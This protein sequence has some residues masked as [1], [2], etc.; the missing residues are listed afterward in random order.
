MD[1]QNMSSIFDQLRAEH[2]ASPEGMPMEGMPADG[3]A[4]PQ[5]GIPTGENVPVEGVPQGTPEQALSADTAMQQNVP[6]NG[7]SAEMPD[8]NQILGTAN[9][10]IQ[11]QQ[12]QIAQLQQQAQ[13]AGQ[14]VQQQSQ[15]AQTAIEQ[16]MLQPPVIDFAQFQY[17]DDEQKSAMFQQYSNDM[18]AYMRSQMEREYAPMMQN[19]KQME[20]NQANEA[21]RS[22]LSQ[23]P[24]FGDNSALIDNIIAK[25]PELAS[26]QNPEL[27][28]QI[29]YLMAEGLGKMN[30]PAPSAP[31]TDDIL[32]MAME[33]PDVLKAI[34]EREAQ[35]IAQ[36]NQ[37]LPQFAATS[38]MSSAPAN[39]PQRPSTM[40]EA[41][42]NIEKNGLKGA[43]AGY[44]AH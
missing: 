4:I 3:T 34:K 16:A 14:A 7:V 41:W 42:G 21:A 1:E 40:E 33:N 25:T 32:K 28:Y 26:I 22:K 8:L 13:Q 38:G 31:T 27:K 37:G 44:F 35:G 24:R 29:A 5:E 18:G 20:A 9:Q 43:S 6:Q 39:V 11:Q 17:A 10:I 23:L 12:A 15:S 19:Y 30:A 36:Q 2:E